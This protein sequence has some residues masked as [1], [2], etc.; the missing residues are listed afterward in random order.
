MKHYANIKPFLNE[1]KF[2][3]CKKIYLNWVFHT[4]NNLLLYDN[5]SLQVR[6][7]SVETKPSLINNES[8]LY[9]KSIIRGNLSNIEIDCKYKLVSKLNG[10]NGYGQESKLLGLNFE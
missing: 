8:L 10:C 6:F 1:E 4:D 7:P 3:N 2:D 9:V 5:R